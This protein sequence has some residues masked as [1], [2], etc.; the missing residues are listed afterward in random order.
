MPCCLIKVSMIFCLFVEVGKKASAFVTVNATNIVFQTLV[1]EYEDNSPSEEF[2]LTC[3]QV[4]ARV[5]QKGRFVNYG[6]GLFTI[7]LVI[8][9]TPCFPIMNIKPPR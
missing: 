7:I 2:M 1:L 5:G 6:T 8:M 9:K 3:H 4:L